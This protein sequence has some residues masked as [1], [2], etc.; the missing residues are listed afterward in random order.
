LSAD[1]HL[2]DEKARAF[3]TQGLEKGKEKMEEAG[4]TNYAFVPVSPELGVE[5]YIDYLK[6]NRV[7][8]VCVGFGMR[9]SSNVALTSFL[10]HL[11]EATRTHSP[12]SKI[13]FNTSPD[14]TVEAAKRWFP[15]Q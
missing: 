4:Y 6:T 3:V 14:S 8:G 9:S 1:Y 5:A 15:L 12:H 10:E 2:F 11:I 13:I 7:D